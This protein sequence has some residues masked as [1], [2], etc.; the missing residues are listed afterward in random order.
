MIASHYV[1]RFHQWEQ[2]EAGSMIGRR[3]R[4]RQKLRQLFVEAGDDAVE[5]FK[6]EVHAT[7]VAQLGADHPVAQ[8]LAPKPPDV[9]E[10][11][12]G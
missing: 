11:G 2:R 10:P 6:G 4:R 12:K 5:T 3:A 9:A 8:L 7:A 1:Q